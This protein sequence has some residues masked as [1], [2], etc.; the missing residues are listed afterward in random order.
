MTVVCLLKILKCLCFIASTVWLQTNKSRLPSSP[1]YLDIYWS[2]VPGCP[3]CSQEYRHFLL[4]FHFSMSSVTLQLLSS[5][6]DMLMIKAFFNGI[7]KALDALPI[8]FSLFLYE[9]DILK[10]LSLS[11]DILSRLW[12]K[13]SLK[14]PNEFLT[15]L[16]DLFISKISVSYAGAAAHRYVF[17]QHTWGCRINPS[18]WQITIKR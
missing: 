17:P 4:W 9:R 2:P 16:P 7:P 6:L 8:I 15:C 11:S 3:D 13:L 10:N 14:L 12:Y 1:V 18:Y 5:P